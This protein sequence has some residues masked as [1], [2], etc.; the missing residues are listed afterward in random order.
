M[1]KP[2]V[3]IIIP[4][5]NGGNYLS[6][7]IE[8]GLL[9][10][11]ENIEIIVINDGS[12][13]G[14]AT[15][16]IA[17]S[18]I[19]KIRYYSKENGGVSSAL[20]F[21]IKKM[22]G[23]WF[24]WLSHDDLYTKDKIERQIIE[25]NREM[26]NKG[27]SVIDKYIVLSNSVLIDANGKKIKNSP[28]FNS[29]VYSGQEMFNAALKGFSINGCS[30]L[31]PRKCFD[32]VGYFDITLRYIQ[33]YDL[34][35]KLMIKRYEFHC[36]GHQ[37]VKMRVHKDQVTAK[38][39]ELF[40]KEREKVGIDLVNNLLINYD[41]NYYMLLNYLNSCARKGNDVV[42]KYILSILKLKDN[43]YKAKYISYKLTLETY[44]YM[45]IFKKFLKEL[46]YRHKRGI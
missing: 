13:D 11:Y 43:N 28:S 34:W 12:N 30:L 32:D 18:Y 27:K 46:Y 41:D 36:I 35:Y 44:K 19:H 22:R 1:Y 9:Q 23:E 8:S 42:G 37:S 33:D 14:G 2:L 16:E 26:K 5:Y 29:G 3:S 45:N 25:V 4:V 7:A 31:L 39:P 38:Y 10:T 40:Y 21:G 24:S 6:K 15:E 17:L 20:N